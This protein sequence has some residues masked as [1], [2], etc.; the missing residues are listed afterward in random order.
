MKFTIWA[1]TSL[2]LS[3]FTAANNAESLF[4]NGMLAMRKGQVEQAVRHFRSAL[5]KSDAPRIKLELALAE[6]QLGQSKEAERLYK[7]V[8]ASNPPANVRANI[9]RRLQVV[10]LAKK[11]GVERKMVRT[12]SGEERKVTVIKKKRWSV[13]VSIGLFY[14]DNVNAGPESD[15]VLIFDLP[16]VLSP[17]AQAQEDAGY[18]LQANYRYQYP[19]GKNMNLVTSLGYSRTGYFE[20]DRFD[21]D[22]LSLSIA[23]QWK[24][25]NCSFSLPLRYGVNWLGGDLYTQSISLSPTLHRR[26]SPRWLSTTNLYVSLNNNDQVSGRDGE[27]VALSQSFRWTSKDG[28]YFVQPR[29]FYGRE[30]ADSEVLASQQVG[31]GIGAYAA[32]LPGDVSL[33]VEPSIRYTKYEA[34]D[35]LFGETRTGTQ[36]RMNINLTRQLPWWDMDVALGYTYTE[37]FSNVD[38]YD[39][40]RNQVSL[41][42]R[43]EF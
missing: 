28:R 13:D 21:Y 29:V 25:G 8:L 24:N 19:L 26:L 4:Q 3:P 31:F 9:E 14:D 41:V 23:P 37:N 40:S 35:P 2:L 27:S 5:Q 38:L 36:F 32:Q 33:Y 6:E 42:F 43:K 15:S 16:F 7:E 1:I 20:N 17:D 39:Y 12:A 30:F 10:A 18:Q 34:A 11:R 22:S